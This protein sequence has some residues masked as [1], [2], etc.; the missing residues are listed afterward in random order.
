[1][2]CVQASAKQITSACE[3]DFFRW[4]KLPLAIYKAQVP[5][6][7]DAS[8]N[9]RLDEVMAQCLGSWADFS[10]IWKASGCDGCDRLASTHI[11]IIIHEDGVPHFSGV[12]YCIMRNVFGGN[13]TCIIRYD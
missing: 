11:P 10:K 4:L 6:K 9:S 5:V 13:W 1:M 3:R 12:S 7:M 8:K 2:L